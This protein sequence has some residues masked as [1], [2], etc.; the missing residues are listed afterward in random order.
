M[1]ERF[2]LDTCGWLEVATEGPLADTFEPYLRDLTRC[3][4]PTVVQ[5]ELFKWAC[6]E[7]DEGIA[8]ELIGLTEHGSVVPLNTPI[9]LLAADLANQHRLAMA[10]A[11]I[12]ATARQEH[13]PLITCD[14]H[15]EDL[16]GVHYTPKGS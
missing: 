2:L 1:S 10:D 11:L 3:I 7:R 16:P 13:A 8:L 15:F 14:R 6:R 9:A 5:F 12:Y 4:V